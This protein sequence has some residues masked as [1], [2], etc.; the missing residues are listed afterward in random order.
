MTD[1]PPSALHCEGRVRVRSRVISIGLVLGKVSKVMVRFKAWFKVKVRGKCPS[2]EL[3]R[4][5]CAAARAQDCSTLPVIR[6]LIVILPVTKPMAN[7]LNQFA[8]V[9]MLPNFS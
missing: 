1:N 6:S 2:W 7:A 8:V 4:G 9:C 5:D 3:S